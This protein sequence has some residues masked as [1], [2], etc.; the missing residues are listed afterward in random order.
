MRKIVYIFLQIWQ[1]TL[2]AL[3]KSKSGCYNTK[4]M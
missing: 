3:A 4:V 1:E 2:N